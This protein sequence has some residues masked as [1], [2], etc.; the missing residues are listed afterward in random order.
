M[1]QGEK[2]N[3]APLALPQAIEAKQTTHN[4]DQIR[5]KKDIPTQASHPTKM[6]WFYLYPDT[7]PHPT[8]YISH[9][10]PEKG[11]HLHHLPIPYLSH[12]VHT[13]LH[14]KDHAV[15]QPRAD[16]RET[17]TNF[18]L[19]IELPGIKDKSELHLRW[20]SMRTLLITSKLSRTE[21]PEDDL[22]DAPAPAP[23]PPQGQEGEAQAEPPAAPEATAKKEPH[24]T[25]H[26]RQ[27]GEILR[28]FNFPVD[29]DRD[30]THAKLDA[31]LLVVVVPKVHHEDVEHPPIPVNVHD[32]PTTT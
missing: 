30:N 8:T 5:R 16:V 18:Y 29:V 21:I 13:K 25:V 32:T 28:A 3:T 2:T 22:S 10:Y 17:L 27:I 23:A 1:W 31:G 12:K 4:E 11:H 7:E 20:T 9:T 15:H 24:L 19:E 26:E 6:S 14:D